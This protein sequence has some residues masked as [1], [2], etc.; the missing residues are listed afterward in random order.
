ML[1]YLKEK[2]QIKDWP[3]HPGRMVREDLR[4][5]EAD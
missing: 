4:E 5:I 2:P 1:H 3:I